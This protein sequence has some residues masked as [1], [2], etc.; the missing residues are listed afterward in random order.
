MAIDYPDSYGGGHA[1]AGV[2][3]TGKGLAHAY[4]A[5]KCGTRRRE[6]SGDTTRAPNGDK[7]ARKGLRATLRR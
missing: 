1:L 6:R 7:T 2:Y 4:E 5:H 3:G